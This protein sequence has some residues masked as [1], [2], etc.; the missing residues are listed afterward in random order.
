MLLSHVDG[1]WVGDSL[2]SRVLAVWFCA[3]VLHRTYQAAYQ[4]GKRSEV[5]AKAN[6]DRATVR[7]SY[8]DGHAISFTLDG[9]A[10]L[11]QR[12]VGLN[13][14]LR[15]VAS[16]LQSV[17]YVILPWDCY[18]EALS[19]SGRATGSCIYWSA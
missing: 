1:R 17:S 16:V 18:L 15:Q 14:D 7:G 2:R 9:G 3:V 19:S 11:K 6:A 13:T 4:T 10:R 5:V 8:T 12:L